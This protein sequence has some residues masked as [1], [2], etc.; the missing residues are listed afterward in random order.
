VSRGPQRCT[1]DGR[2]RFSAVR[3]G[4]CFWSQ[5][6]AAQPL[7]EADAAIAAV[8]SGGLGR[9]GGWSTRRLRQSRRAA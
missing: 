5:G 7:A 9:D 4:G 2:L 8:V 1:G 3:F 6:E